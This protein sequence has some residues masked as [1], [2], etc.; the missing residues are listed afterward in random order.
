ME[1]IF[2]DKEFIIVVKRGLEFETSEL[3]HAL[4]IFG[5][6]FSKGY[7]DTVIKVRNTK[8]HWDYLEGK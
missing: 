6:W 2:K 4:K 8:L 5:E 7:T 1:T 3:D